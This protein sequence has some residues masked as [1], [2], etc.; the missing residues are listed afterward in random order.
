MALRVPERGLPSSRPGGPAGDL[1]VV[2]RTAPDPRFERRG[3]DL[4]HNAT[5]QIADAVLGTAMD[6]PTLDG[7]V[8]VKVPAGTQPGSVLRLRNKGLPVFRGTG[9]GALYV[10]I[11]VFVPQHL[12]ARERKLY[13]QL[14]TLAN[15]PAGETGKSA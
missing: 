2:I 6:V 7:S 1:F 11:Q 13:E 4:W 9:P 12:S 8:S 15:S 14:R 5:I 10:S 3:A